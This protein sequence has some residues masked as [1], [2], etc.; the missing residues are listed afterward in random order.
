MKSASFLSA[1]LCQWFY[2]IGQQATCPC[3]GYQ[4]LYSL[5]WHRLIGIA[6]PIINLRRSSGH[7]RFI[8]GILGPERRRILV[9]EVT[10]HAVGLRISGKCN[11]LGFFRS[12]RTEK[13]KLQSRI[14]H[15]IGYNQ[16]N[17][18]TF[19]VIR[20][21]CTEY[22]D[23]NNNKISVRSY[24]TL[25]CANVDDSMKQYIYI[26]YIIKQYIYWKQEVFLL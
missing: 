18:Y 23:D 19:I 17:D 12:R 1:V 4:G 13:F 11:L 3:R 16:S 21:T 24:W 7:L 6:S 26:H 22:I 8:M 5:R 20:K 25:P 10:F 15:F 2:M 9:A 14:L